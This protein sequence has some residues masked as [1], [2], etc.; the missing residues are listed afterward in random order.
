MTFDDGPHPVWTPRVLAALERCGASATFFVR[1]GERSEPI[2]R[3]LEAG[4][5]VGYHCGR[6]VRHSEREHDEVAREAETDLAILRG[7]GTDPSRWRTPWGDQAPWTADLAADLGLELV[8]WSDDP[9]DWAGHSADSMLAGL[10]GGLEVGS[11][12]LMHD[13]IGPGAR[14]DGC[15]ETVELIEPL[16]ELAHERGLPALSLAE[17]SVPR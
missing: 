13:G 11:V 4:H 15:E 17:R 2:V 12:V 3:A 9:E 16:A 10:R 6:H 1:P 8:G 7:L 14:R 5:E